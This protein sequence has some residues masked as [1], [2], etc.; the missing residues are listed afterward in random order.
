M[1]GLTVINHNGVLVTDSREVAE[2]VE[3]RHADLLEKV[4][5]YNE[6]LL[7]GKFRSAEYFIPST[8]QDSTGRTLPCYL[9]TKKGCELVAN[10]LTGKKGT[11]FT[12]AYV[13]RFNVMEQTIQHGSLDDKSMTQRLRAEAMNMNAKTRQAA[14]W[15]KIGDMIPQSMEHKKLCASYASEALT[16]QRVIALPQ[17]ERTYTATEVGQRYGI[18]ANMVGKIA[19]AH[20]L[21]TEEFGIFALDKSRYSAKEVESFRYNERGAQEVGKYVGARDKSA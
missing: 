2:M 4:N 7:N 11:L 17:V 10:K 1:N 18:S 6:I 20:G 19:N 12:A 16:G 13:D 9:L 5:G 21:K 8:Y 15:V 14:M 3:M